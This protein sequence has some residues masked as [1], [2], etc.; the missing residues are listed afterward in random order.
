MWEA[1]QAPWENGA[2]TGPSSGLYKSVDGGTT[3]SANLAGSLPGHTITRIATSPSNAGRLFISMANFGHGHVFR[4]DDGGASWRDVDGG[5]L[6]D[7]PHQAVLVRPDAPKT[8]WVCGDAG[9]YASYDEGLTWMNLTRNLPR[10]MVVDLVFQEARKW[11]VA[12]T[13]GRSVYRLAIE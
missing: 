6:P 8:I 10:V 4:S 12:A 11:L 1:R 3:W 9:V 13:Y 2:F 5:Q 7:V